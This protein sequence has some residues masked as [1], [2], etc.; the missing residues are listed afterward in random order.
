MTES[1]SR[2]KA[3]KIIGLTGGSGVGKSVVASA[4][5]DKG[6]GWVDADAV[7][8]GLCVPG[9]ELLATLEQTFGGVLTADGHLDRPALAKKVFSDKAALET[10]NGIT[11]PRIRAAMAAKAEEYFAAGCPVV[12]YDAP[13]LFQTGIDADC[14]CVIG[15]VAA[16]E[17]RMMRIMARDGLSEEAA[18]ARIANQPENVFYWSRCDHIIEN[19]GTAEEAAASAAALWEKLTV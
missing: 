16:R 18:A 12:L 10:L 11:T 1:A 2:T 4:L 13:T 19:N 9:S 3:G 17:T 8:H 5:A 14:D 6:A 7:Y 15:V